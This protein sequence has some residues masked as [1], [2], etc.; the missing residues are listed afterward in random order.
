MATRRKGVDTHVS[1]IRIGFTKENPVCVIPFS[2][3]MRI[4]VT[5]VT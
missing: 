3:H 4:R 5:C 2:A 1:G